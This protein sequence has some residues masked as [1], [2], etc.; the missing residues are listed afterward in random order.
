MRNFERLLGRR[1]SAQDIRAADDES[2]LAAWKGFRQSLEA[3]GKTGSEIECPLAVGEYLVHVTYDMPRDKATLEAEFSK[4]GVSD[5][6]TG[7]YE[8]QLHS[9]CAEINQTPGERIMLVKHF[10]RDTTSEANIAEMDKLGYRPATHL[11]AYAFQKANP[12]LQR[13]FWIVALGSSAV[14]DGHRRVAVLFGDSGRRLLGLDCF[15][16]E[17]YSDLRFLFVRK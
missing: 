14:S 4:D 5:L 16:L 9:S 3:R 12:E 17:W 6:F 7:N 1:F 8:W 2:V 10:G 15:D 13:R 11:E